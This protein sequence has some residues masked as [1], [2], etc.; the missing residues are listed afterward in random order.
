[1]LYPE[2]IN[3]ALSEFYRPEALAGIKVTTEF[4]KY[5]KQN[6]QPLP[7]KPN[8]LPYG[9]VGHFTGVPIEIDDD[10]DG[11]YEFVF[12]KENDNV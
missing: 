1:M 10:I 8:R 2:K 5:L 11:H 4:A 6:V 3:K 12:N 7:E 9:I